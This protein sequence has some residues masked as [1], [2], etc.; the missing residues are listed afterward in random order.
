MLSRPPPMA[1]I[2]GR[3]N[4]P[5]LGTRPARSPPS[6]D[7]PV[8]RDVLGLE[9]LQQS[10]VAPLAADPALLD[11]AEGR[12]RVGDEPPVQ[13]DHARPDRFGDGQPLGQG[14]RV[15]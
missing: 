3:R 11:S 1:A 15:Y 10:L 14:A 8:G 6:A 13:A 4:S 12:R 9:K 2:T 7:L 5:F